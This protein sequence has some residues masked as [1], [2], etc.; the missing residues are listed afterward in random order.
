[1][2]YL[3][4]GLTFVG[5]LRLGLILM[6]LWNFFAVWF[7]Y[8]SVVDERS[9]TISYALDRENNCILH[10]KS[11]TYPVC[12]SEYEASLRGYSGWA[13]FKKQLDPLR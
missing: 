3:T 8:K 5:L 6:I 7:S 13:K 4:N 10:D 11:K 12:N 9:R 1:V 2:K